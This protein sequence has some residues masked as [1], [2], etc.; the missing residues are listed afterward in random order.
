MAWKKKILLLP[1]ALL[2]LG[3][4]CSTDS[5]YDSSIT[6]DSYDTSSFESESNSDY[7]CDCSKT[8][9]EI[10]SCDEAY[11]QLDDCGCSVRD[12]DDDGV[13]CENIC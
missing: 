6:E 11:F 5:Y 2:L 1:I 9:E 13:P 12:G 7:S 3:S 4:A 8:C 10:Y